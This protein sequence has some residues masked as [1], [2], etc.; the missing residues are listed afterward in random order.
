MV[1]PFFFLL[2][3]IPKFGKGVLMRFAELMVS[4]VLKRIITTVLL[5]VYFI[6]YSAIATSDAVIIVQI[7]AIAAVA[8]G[9]LYA[10]KLFIGMTANKVDFGGDKRLGLP[11]AK[12]ASWFAGLGGAAAG[13]VAGAGVGVAAGPLAPVVAAAG[14]LLGGNKARKDAR[15]A[16]SDLEGTGFNSP[17]ADAKRPAR[18]K[19][20]APF[21]SSA[22]PKL[23]GEAAGAAAKAT[24]VG[25]PVAGVA[26]AGANAATKKVQ[27]T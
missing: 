16:N 12:A 14:S 4:I 10:R 27:G 7:F 5:A 20:S 15:S 24:G 21:P 2:G 18:S 6:F 8:F 22:A 23:A 1:S 11:G 9:T 17:T 13:G 19:G 25:A 3:V 26:K